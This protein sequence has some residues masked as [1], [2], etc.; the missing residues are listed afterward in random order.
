MKYFISKNTFVISLVLYSLAIGCSKDPV[1]EKVIGT[2]LDSDDI[3]VS[4]LGE[5]QIS[6]FVWKG[7]NEF[8]YWQE[9]VE[10]LS[11]DKLLDQKSYGQYISENPNAEPFFESLKHPD[12]RFSWIQ[13][14]YK[15]L[16]NSLQGIIASNGVEFGLL[17]ACQ[18]CNQLV[19]F[20][21][22]ILEGSDA[23]N[24]NIQRG[25]FFIGVNGTI[26][27]ASNYRSLLFG[28]NL[29]YTLNMA[30]AK[31][32]ALAINGINIELTKEENF[33]TNPIQISKS[34]TFN[35][36][37]GGYTGNLGY[38]MYNQFVADKSNELNKVFADFKAEGIS[39]L[40]IDLRYNGGG[41]VQNCVEL[42]SMI[43][44]QFTSEIFAEEQW[45]NKLLKYL[46]ERFGKE[47]LINRFTPQLS[48]GEPINSLNLNRVFI[49]TTSES[50]SA[51][52]LL[53]NGLDS[54]I[55]VIHVG[56]RTVGKN[57]GSITVYDYIDN[58]QTKNPEHTYAMQPIVL[59]IANN[60]GFADY[61]DGL[62]PDTE[63]EEDIRDLGV[64]GDFNERML[65]AVVDI[66]TGT[67]KRNLPKA[68]MSRALLVN[69]P[70]LLL[71]QQMIVEK[72]ELLSNSR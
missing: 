1:D 17:Y 43:T 40:I 6:D 47:S 42:A 36:E 65:K 14:D 62:I 10:D 9:D 45:N 8:Y 26:L 38:I 70:L 52:E 51:S 64:L 50:A 20:V 15:V 61:S 39:D 63:I 21:K 59:K 41:S 33:K 48:N 16:E 7:L 55:D 44:G 68:K 4:L 19:G 31:N 27:T 56:E 13:D 30:S 11:D 34:I 23:E 57:V 5:L 54:Y 71:R 28:D 58:E 35:N 49:I 69:D 3:A 67:G 22:Y 60:D 25:D 24:K 12:D 2:N 29:T 72:K 53:I 32:G 18:N 46:R 37:I 66:I